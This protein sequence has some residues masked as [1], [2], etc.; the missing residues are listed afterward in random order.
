MNT[1][2]NNVDEVFFHGMN[3]HKRDALYHFSGRKVF[4]YIDMTKEFYTKEEIIDC[5]PIWAWVL[6][7]EELL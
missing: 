5:D 2:S 6:R 1:L 4:D 3:R 7:D